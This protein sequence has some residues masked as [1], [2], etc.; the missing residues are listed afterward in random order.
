MTQVK[1]E[2]ILEVRRLEGLGRYSQEKVLMQHGNF[3]VYDHSR[4]V[5]LCSV[6]L[7]EMA[8]WKVDR[9]SLIRGALLHDY[10]LYD[11]HDHQHVWHGPNHP[12]T[13]LNNAEQDYELS[14][15]ERDII[16]RHMFPLNPIPPKTKEGWIV[17]LADKICALE[18]SVHPSRFSC[19]ESLRRSWRKVYHMAKRTLAKSNMLLA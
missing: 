14:D 3:S 18:E 17:C 12:H 7:A 11:W 9:E 6:R 13:A 4:R 8:S 16:S 2:I 5:A 1:R 19:Y 15:R 10:F